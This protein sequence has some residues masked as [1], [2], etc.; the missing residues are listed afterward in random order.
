MTVTL[1]DGE[2]DPI[3]D[4]ES[5]GRVRVQDRHL[6]RPGGKVLAKTVNR[7]WHKETAKKV[8]DLGHRHRQPHRHR[9]QPRLDLPGRRR[10]RQWRTTARPTPSTPPP[11]ASPRPRTWATPPPRHDD[12]CTRTTYAANTTVILNLPARVETVAEACARHPGRPSDVIVRRPHRL[13]RRRL[14]RRARPRATPP[15]R[16]DSRATTAPAHLPGVR[17]TYDAYGRALTVTDLTANV[18]VTTGA[19]HPAPPAPT[20]APPPPPT[21]PTTGFPTEHHVTTPPATPGDSATAQTTTTDLRPAARPAARPDRHQRQASPT[22]HVRRAGPQHQGVAAPTG[23]GQQDTR[24]TSSPTPSPTAS[25]SRSAPRRSATPVR[26]DTSYTL[27]DGFLRPP[28]DPGPRPDGGTLL[29]DTFYDER[30]LTAKAFAPYYATEHALHDLFKPDDA[31]G[32]ETQTRNTYD[33]L[34]RVTRAEA[35]RRQR[36]RRHG[37]GDHDDA[38]RRRPHHR[39]PAGGRHRPPPRSPTPAATPPN[40]A[41]TTPRRRPAPTTRTLLRLHRRAAS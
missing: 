19:R 20:A 32:V 2:G 5:R 30:G 15:R 35:D 29:T 31:L 27:Y 39:H 24:T 9:Q 16:Q 40:C 41:S 17:S 13:R 4:H 34:G 12:Q 22:L 6:L 25:R 33:G 7:P 1:D 36:R 28:P 11:A 38:L 23:P 18:T 37:P 14:R 10:R 21:P 26:Q 8:R 3:T